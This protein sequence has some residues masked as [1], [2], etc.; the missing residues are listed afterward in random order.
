MVKGSF[1][2]RPLHTLRRYFCV[3][4]A[5]VAPAAEAV[6]AATEANRKAVAANT[7]AGI[8]LLEELDALSGM[9]RHE[10]REG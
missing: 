9:I 5:E 8:R 7:A 10:G 4:P 1:W 3:M 2:L 6:R